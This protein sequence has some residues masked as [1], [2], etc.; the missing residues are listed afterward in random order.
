MKKITDYIINGRGFGILPLLLF[1]L[2]VTII[3]SIKLKNI[4]DSAVPYAQQVAD[5]ILP[6]K[7]EHGRVITPND[8]KQT[9]K[10]KISE[11]MP[12]VQIPFVIDTTVDTLNPT[13]LK[14][15]IYLT[16]TAFYTVGQRQTKV[17]AL[18]DSLDIPQGD[19]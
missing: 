4:G 16:K 13:K 10:I 18:S 6:I 15:G 17:M 7:I 12:E 8:I 19:Y 1:T 2:I 5:Q 11:D 9:F 14:E 3:F